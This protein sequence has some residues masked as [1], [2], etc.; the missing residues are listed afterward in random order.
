L[1]ICNRLLL[2]TINY[3]LPNGYDFEVGTFPLSEWLEAMLQPGK[4]PNIPID[5]F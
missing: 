2:F 1:F 3:F 4:S 5:Y